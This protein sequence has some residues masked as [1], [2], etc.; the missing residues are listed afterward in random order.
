MLADC[1]ASAQIPTPH[2]PSFHWQVPS[3]LVRIV[4]KP[5][6]GTKPLRP[7]GLRAAAFFRMTTTTL[8][9]TRNSE[10]NWGCRNFDTAQPFRCGFFWAGSL[11]KAGILLKCRM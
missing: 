5:E 11:G 2:C 3:G 7:T 10:P 1:V 8:K 9:H 4:R 6:T